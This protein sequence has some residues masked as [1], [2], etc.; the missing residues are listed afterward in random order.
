[1]LSD[2]QKVVTE[3]EGTQYGGR[4]RLVTAYVAQGE[5]QPAQ[6]MHRL[7]MRV[8]YAHLV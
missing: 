5:L 1:M 6:N 7:H 8:V 2:M 3:V 4:Y